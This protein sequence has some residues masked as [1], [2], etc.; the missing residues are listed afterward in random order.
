MVSSGKPWPR[1]KRICRPNT[2]SVPVPVRSSRCTPFARMSAQQVEVG[3]VEGVGDGLQAG[4][5]GHAPSI[6]GFPPGASRRD[7]APN[8]V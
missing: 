5:G 2:P 4:D 3:L 6:P 7:T 1:S 8:L